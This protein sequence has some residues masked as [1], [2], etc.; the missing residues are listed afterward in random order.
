MKD[1][2]A[3]SGPHAA[4][5][6]IWLCPSSDLLRRRTYGLRATI[7]LAVALC[8]QRATMSTHSAAG[9][10]VTH[11]MELLA[12]APCLPPAALNGQAMELSHRQA[13]RRTVWD[14]VGRTTVF[15]PIRV[16]LPRTMKFYPFFL[17]FFVN[18]SC[19]YFLITCDFR[20]YKCSYFGRT[21][22]YRA[23]SNSASVP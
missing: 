15:I 20:K 16:D 21:N 12:P 22:S 5:P 6:K 8:S 11:S 17:C 7:L 23:D 10:R 14:V 1:P 9:H 13:R 19:D 2:R 4:P 3:A 18:S